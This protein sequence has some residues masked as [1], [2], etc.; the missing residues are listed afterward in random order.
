MRRTASAM[1]FSALFATAVVATNGYG[2]R[3]EVPPTQADAYDAKFLDELQRL[4]GRFSNADLHHVFQ[5]TRPVK[6][7]E[8]VRDKGE[9]KDVA[10][11][12]GSRKW[13][14]SSLTELK[15]NP[16]VYIFQGVC[17]DERTALKVTTKVPLDEN[18][19][20]QERKIDFGDAPVKVNPPVKA[21]FNSDNK[22]YA[23]DLPY[24]FYGRDEDGKSVFT[25]NPRRLSDKY[26]T[27]ITS[28]WE[29][30]T[31]TEEYLTYEFLICHTQ[32]FG[33]EPVDLKRRDKPTYSFN[34]SAYIIL[35]NGKESP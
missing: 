27:H 34:A 19:G 12:N 31:L 14:S 18:A 21:S 30:K 2:Q 10:F 4:F 26:L 25:F 23:F 6:C 33:L 5:T 28:H 32:L 35:S 16:A 1:L 8:L 13:Y 22:S 15:N 11:F 9:W 24:L 29:C 3:H 7:Y 20:Y 17:G